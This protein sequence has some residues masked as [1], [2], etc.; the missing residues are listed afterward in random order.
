MILLGDCL[1]RMK[2]LESESVDCIIVDPPYGTTACEWD[3]VIPFESMWKELKRIS[4]IQTAICVFGSE[5]FSSKLRMSA[6]ELFKYDWIWIKNKPTGH[7]H[8]KN[9]PMKK[10]EIVSVFSKG[11]TLHKGQ[12]EKRMRYFPQ[13][14]LKLEK[15]I[16]HKGDHS[17]SVV[18]GKRPSHKDN[19]QEFT[20]YP[21]S[22]LFFDG[23]FRGDH[24]TQK[25]VEL[26]EYL[27]KTYTQEGDTV[28]DFTM[29]SGSTGVAAFKS[30]RKFIGIELNESYVEIA[31]RRIAHAKE[32][33]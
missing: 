13:G 12:S 20:N 30:K 26:L 2:E 22:V 33:A 21:S 10:H 15:P 8:A 32:G 3:S 4:K 23:V 5:P 29:G 6:I 9:R 14:L 28:L 16:F 11:N 19:I 7:V 1:E 31:R 18:M 17:S 25:P 24:P 27:I